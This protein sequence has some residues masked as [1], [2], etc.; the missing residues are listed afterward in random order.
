[1]DYMNDVWLRAF[2]RN[3]IDGCYIFQLEDGIP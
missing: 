3:K 2:V 1:M